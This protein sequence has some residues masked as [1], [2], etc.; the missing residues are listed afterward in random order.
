MIVS[1]FYKKTN[2]FKWI[3]PILNRNERKTLAPM[4][5]KRFHWFSFRH[6]LPGVKICL[7][8][9]VFNPC[10]KYILIS[11]ITIDNKRKR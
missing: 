11:A 4:K 9:I 6:T 10:R 5:T 2:D 8:S 1:L 7:S 3:D